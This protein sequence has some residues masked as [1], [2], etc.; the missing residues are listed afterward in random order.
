MGKYSVETESFA[1]TTGDT[2]CISVNADT[3]GDS[4][5][6]VEAIMTGSNAAAADIQHRATLTRSDATVIAAGGTAATPEPFNPKSAASGMT[7]Q[8][9]TL[10]TEPTVKGVPNVAFGFNQRGGMRWAVPRGE[11]VFFANEDANDE[12]LNLTVDSS[13][14]GGIDGNIHWWEP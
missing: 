7:V 14:V 3:A 9:G 5:E 6:C 12:T 13:A 1:T 4:G 2:V 8:E 11:G 10:N